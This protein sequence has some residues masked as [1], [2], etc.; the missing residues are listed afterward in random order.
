[1][2]CQATGIDIFSNCYFTDTV[3]CFVTLFLL[4]V[5]YC[6]KASVCLSAQSTHRPEKNVS[7]LKF[8]AMIYHVGS[9]CMSHAL[10]A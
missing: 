2:G 8:A 1:V 3:T 4:Y 10:F 7:S 9:Q 5:S 6:L